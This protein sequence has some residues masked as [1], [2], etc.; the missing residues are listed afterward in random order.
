MA[1]NHQ[2]KLYTTKQIEYCHYAY[3]LVYRRSHIVESNVNKQKQAIR[4]N[5]Q[6]QKY[7]S[8]ILTISLFSILLINK[9][10]RILAM[11]R[12]TNGA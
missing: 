8:L 9:G 7:L 10:K 2:R 3:N 5:A 6:Y 12:D 1:V 11:N 4:H